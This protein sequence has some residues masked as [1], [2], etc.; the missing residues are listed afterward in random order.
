VVRKEL[1]TTSSNDWTLHVGVKD[2]GE[3]VVKRIRIKKK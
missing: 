3:L 2:G 1:K